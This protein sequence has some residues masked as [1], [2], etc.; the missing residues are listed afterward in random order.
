MCSD[1]E[2][3]KEKYKTIPRVDEGVL[4]FVRQAESNTR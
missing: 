1:R 2:E 4:I 3:M